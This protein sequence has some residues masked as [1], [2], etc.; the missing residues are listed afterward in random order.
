MSEEVYQNLAK[1]LD[2]LPSGFPSTASGVEIKSLE[3]IFT[4]G[5]DIR[6]VRRDEEEI[7]PPPVDEINWFKERG[8]Q[9]GI[10]FGK[11]E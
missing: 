4:P 1:V 6:L 3:K 7:I 11:Y 5:E 10:D 8:R 9:R 2:T